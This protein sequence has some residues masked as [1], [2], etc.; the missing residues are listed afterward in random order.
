MPIGGPQDL[1]R[2]GKMLFARTAVI[3]A[4]CVAAGAMATAGATAQAGTY[5]ST[6]IHLIVGFAPGGASDVL[7]RLLADKLTVILGQP[8]IVENRGGAAGTIGAGAVSRANP[9]GYTLLSASVSNIVLAKSIIPNVPYDPLSGFTPIILT[10]SAPLILVVPKS[11][12]FGSVADLVAAAKAKPGTLNF[13]SGGVGTSVHLAGALFNQ[14]AGVDILH[15]PFNGDA[16]AVVALL[17]NSVS[18]TFAAGPSVIS[19]LQSG[20]LRPL[21]VAAARR[22][23]SMPNVP[24]IAE[25]GIPGFEVNVWHGLFAPPN[26]PKTVVDKLHDAVA[27]IQTMPDV[28]Q[29]LANIGFEPGG[30]S[31]D[32][33][34]RLIGADVKKWPP[35]IAAA[36]SAGK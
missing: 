14:M 13:S 33:L 36:V 32:D 29:T 34:N 2:T 20:D 25:A 21:A 5:P 19:L 31:T 16:P 17:A 8:V 27:K 26:T 6:T 23:S 18:M 9:D 30:G 10:A 12:P 7:A 24:T 4:W 22:L 28:Q 35:I 3:I 11:S 1:R 15:I